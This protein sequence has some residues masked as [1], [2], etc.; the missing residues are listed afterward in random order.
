MCYR[1]NNE[2]TRFF[3][4]LLLGGV[5]CGLAALLFA[6]KEGRKL[7]K[8]ICDQCSDLKRRAMD[9][10]HDVEEVAGEFS[11]HTK[12]LAKKLMRRLSRYYW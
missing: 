1:C 10:E 7:R 5:V 6:P 8:E 12:K 4:G 3:T 9:A 11:T 2:K